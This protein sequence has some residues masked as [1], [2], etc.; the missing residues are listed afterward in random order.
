MKQSNGKTGEK[1]KKSEKCDQ[2]EMRIKKL[3]S[4]KMEEKTKQ[5]IKKK[6]T[7]I[8]NASPF[9]VEKDDITYDE[10]VTWGFQTFRNTQNGPIQWHTKE[11]RATSLQVY[12]HR[13]EMLK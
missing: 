10:V 13:E 4:K 9:T 6:V 2:A 1:A 3:N 11:V 5:D 12:C 8:V 7:I